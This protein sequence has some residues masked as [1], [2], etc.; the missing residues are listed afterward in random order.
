VI[1]ADTS[2]W[3][4]HFRRTNS[5]FEKF[6]AAGNVVTHP[7][8]IGEIALGYLKRRDFVLDGLRAMPQA[9]VASNEE[10]LEFIDQHS[11]FGLG[12]GYVD[13]H[14]LAATRL[15]VGVSLWTRDKRLSHAA[16]LLAVATVDFP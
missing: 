13:S 4:E 16:Q 10:V 7:F 15:N 8:V 14:L 1:L 12:I 6:L 2:I 9:L 3:V 11:L 5:T